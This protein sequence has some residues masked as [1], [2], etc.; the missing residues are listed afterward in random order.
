MLMVGL[1]C[2]AGPAR[3]NTLIYNSSF[4]IDEDPADGTPDRWIMWGSDW[5]W[6]GGSIEEFITDDPDGAH[7]G[8]AYFRGYAGVG[9]YACAVP[10]AE[11][12]GRGGPTME[13]QDTYFVGAWVK[14]LMPDGQPSVEPPGFEIGYY[15]EAGE[16][17]AD[18][19]GRFWYYQAMRW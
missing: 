15:N 18:P 13:P 7:T 19:V 9:D 11:G 2:L 6:W 8:S 1:L 12:G 17:L 5:S 4:E 3:A 10:Q 14:D 16:R